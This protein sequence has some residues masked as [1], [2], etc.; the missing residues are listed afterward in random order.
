VCFEECLH[1]GLKGQIT[2]KLQ[3][4]VIITIHI[5][6][7]LDILAYCENKT[8]GFLTLQMFGY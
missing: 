7:Q 5:R 8:V 3:L 1:P 6:K 4:G 2:F